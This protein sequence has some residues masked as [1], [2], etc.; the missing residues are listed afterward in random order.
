MKRA[1]AALALCLSLSVCARGPA[2]AP[3][4]I[5]EGGDSGMLA[6]YYRD[7]YLYEYEKDVWV[8]VDKWAPPLE[9]VQQ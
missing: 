1:L 8:P 9:G 6:M 3:S 5:V 7:G 4:H 2:P